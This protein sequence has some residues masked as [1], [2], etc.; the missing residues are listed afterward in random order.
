MATLPKLHKEG[1]GLGV[2]KDEFS[3]LLAR[4][5]RLNKELVSYLSDS[6]DAQDEFIENLF[7]QFSTVEHL[8]T[9][10][11][12]KDFFEFRIRHAIEEQQKVVAKGCCTVLRVDDLVFDNQLLNSQELL[13][14]AVKYKAV[15][16]LIDLGK[17]V[18]VAQGIMEAAD[19]YGAKYVIDTIFT[20]QEASKAPL[21]LKNE[22]PSHPT[23][24]STIPASAVATLSMRDVM[25]ST[26]T[27]KYFIHEVLHINVTM[28]E[29]NIVAWL[30]AHFALG[31]AGG[32]MLLPDASHVQTFGAAAI[33]TANYGARLQLYEN[34]HQY[35]NNAGIMA[36]VGGQVVLSLVGGGMAKLLI[37]GLGLQSAIYDSVVAGS[38]GGLQ[39]YQ[40]YHH[41]NSKPKS[42]AEMV[43][44]YVADMIAGYVAYKHMHLPSGGAV[45]YMLLTKQVLT[46]ISTIVT[47]DYIT[48]MTTNIISDYITTN[49]SDYFDDYK[50]YLSSYFYVE[51]ESN[52]S[53]LD[54][55]YDME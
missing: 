20:P 9:R 50:D 4:K 16:Q 51:N 30:G 1:I 32:M 35:T 3:S 54:S 34:I 37:P 49:F 18:D 13:Q 42:V 52:N 28:P 5:I 25:E 8:A 33:G 55:M 29:V 14:E 17:D 23:A 36:M 26:P 24:T 39:Y 41:D 46:A 12:E 27:I 38:I 31:A 40:M 7:H 47:T 43:I 6:V 44:P 53:T 22:I 15:S 45:S 48:K 21:L 19:Q 11:K 10:F 2:A